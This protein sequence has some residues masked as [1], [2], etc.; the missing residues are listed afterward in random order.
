[1]KYIE[2]DIYEGE[3]ANDLRHGQATYTFANGAILK[4]KWKNDMPHDDNGTG[5]IKVVTNFKTVFE[6]GALT[7][8]RL[9]GS[10]WPL[11]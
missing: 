1:M 9:I 5:T 4:C 7:D 8:I 3:Y 6:N 11:F 10:K 2:G